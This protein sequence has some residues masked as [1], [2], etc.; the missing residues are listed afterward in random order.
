MM[1]AVRRLSYG[2]NNLRGLDKEDSG[3]SDS[4]SSASSYEEFQKR[5]ISKVEK[6]GVTQ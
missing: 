6:R 3:D 4:N 2:P 1:E 5:S